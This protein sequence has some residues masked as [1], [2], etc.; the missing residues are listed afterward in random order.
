MNIEDA[1]KNRR[2]NYP[3]QYSGEK[4]PL[5]IVEKMMELANWAPTHLK[6][7]PW[8]F[9]V[10]SNQ[11]KKDLLELCKECYIKET[12]AESFKAVKIER[13]EERKNQVSH[14]IA[15]CM[16]RHQELPEFEEVSSVA[17]AVQNMWLYL[18][19]T[20]KYG[21]YWS[22]PKFSRGDHFRQFLK[23]DSDEFCLGI[24]YVGALNNRSDIRTG[25]RQNWREKVVYRN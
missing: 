10:F 2:S 7:E 5:E 18:T 22:S 13:F 14:I 17:M 9:K 4:V 12:D 24:F 19:S 11:S 8:R 3:K 21:G 25:H 20:K 16:K 23:L 1:I 15:I 6:T